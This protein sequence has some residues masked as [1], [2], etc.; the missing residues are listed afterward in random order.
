MGRDLAIVVLTATIAVAIQPFA[1]VANVDYPEARAVA[2]RID[3]A[4]RSISGGA[5]AEETVTRAGLRLHIFDVDGRSLMVLTDVERTSTGFCYAIRFGPGILSEAG[6]LEDPDSACTPE[7]LGVFVR[8][9]SWSEILPSERITPPWFI[10]LMV[11][12]FAA[13]LYALVDISIVLVTRRETLASL[14]RGS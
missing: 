1:D 6:V 7:S 5:D 3:S 10:P 8:G 2:D 13:G 14:G 12:L 9:G 4:W 11:L